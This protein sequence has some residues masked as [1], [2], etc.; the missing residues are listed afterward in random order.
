[1]KHMPYWAIVSMML[2]VTVFGGA[3]DQPATTQPTT[4]KRQLVN[5]DDHEICYETAGQG[6]T[7][8]VFVHCWTCNQ[9]FWDDQFTHF[10]KDY[11]VVRLDL[12][13]HGDSGKNRQHYSMQAFGR[14]VAAVVN[15]LDLKR[16]VIIGHSMGGP[17]SVEAAK[18][19]GDRVIG[20]VGV[21]TF[22]TGFP[23]PKT[24]EEIAGFVKPFEDD[25]TATTTGMVTN[26]FAPGTD[27]ALVERAKGVILKADQAMAVEAMYDIF[28]WNRTQAEASLA[29]LGPRLR[30]I[31]GDPVAKEAP[32]HTSV[33]RVAGTGH[34]VQ[35]EKPQAFNAT[36]T[37]I[38][39]E[40][41]TAN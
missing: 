40:L 26:M 37:E 33:R 2:V 22:F 36:L 15:A 10:A 13:G 9:S 32:Q 7:A 16:V 35:M 8:L 27:P 14:D 23:Y 1:M 12:A 25:F 41:E 18:L 38:V 31:N 21:D 29:A 39:N 28:E 34:F 17:V 4:S 30:N 3:C 24:D 19:L 11:Q 20:V 5:S 6:K